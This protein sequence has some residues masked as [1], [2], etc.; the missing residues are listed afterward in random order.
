MHNS[1]K[2]TFRKS[3]A[4]KNLSR[5]W[6]LLGRIEVPNLSL[7]FYQKKI[8]EIIFEVNSIDQKKL[9]DPIKAIYFLNDLLFKKHHFVGRSEHFKN[10][11]DEPRRFFLHYLLDTKEG[12]PLT[13]AVLY[14]LMAERIGLTCELIGVPNYYFIKVRDVT[15]SI[16]IDPFEYGMILNEDGFAKRFQQIM[17]KNMILTSHLY[18]KL[19]FVQIITRLIQ[20]LKQSYLLIGN[21]ICALY[22]I[23]VLS[24]LFP[25]SPEISRDRG[26]LYFEVEYFSHAIKDLKYYLKHRPNAEDASQ[27]RQLTSMLRGYSEVVN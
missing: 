23:E 6:L 9:K 21:T 20:Q 24:M 2:G 22:S 5:M 1:L 25:K 19:T 18:E 27:I 3:I 7:Q 16:Y 4:S 13:M 8:L 15:G 12:N 10:K 26:I 14:Y 11:I 17:K